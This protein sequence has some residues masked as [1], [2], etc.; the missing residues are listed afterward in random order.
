MEA[1]AD[2]AWRGPQALQCSMVRALPPCSLMS[3]GLARAMAGVVAAQAQALVLMQV[4]VLGHGLQGPMISAVPAIGQATGRNTALHH[5]RE[6]L[7]HILIGLVVL[8][9]VH[10]PPG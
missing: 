10:I 6:Q 5:G 8:I 9:E 3:A 2:P 1:M 4:L 7:F